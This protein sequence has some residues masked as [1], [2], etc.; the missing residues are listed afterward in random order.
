MGNYHITKGDDGW[1]LKK[2]GAQRP[3]KRAATK[4]ELLILTADFL[5]NKIAS[6]MI[7]QEDGT[8]QEER[9]YP[10]SADSR[11]SKG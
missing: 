11:I 6:L 10:R 2:E 7:H 9:S 4:D 3:S 1:A 8:L 5:E